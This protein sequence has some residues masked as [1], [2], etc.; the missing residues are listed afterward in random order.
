MIGSCR[1][2]RPSALALLAGVLTVTVVVG[3]CGDDGPV[4][5][6]GQDARV[7]VT[8]ETTTT[9][10]T[11]IEEPPR[12][13]DQGVDGALVF[14][15]HCSGCHGPSGGGGPFAPSLAAVS[16]A[17]HVEQQ[18][19]TGGGRMPELGSRLDDEQIAAVAEYV[20]DQIAGDHP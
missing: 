12:P 18:V 8:P 19:R 14:A 20:A 4:V 10:S 7:V 2:R 16:D 13:S 9:A 17:G 3:G 6:P 1:H 15:Q 11:S 5:S